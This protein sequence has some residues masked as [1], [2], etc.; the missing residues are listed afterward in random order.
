[1]LTILAPTYTQVQGNWTLLL[2]DYQSKDPYPH[3]GDTCGGL[4][5][6]YVRDPHC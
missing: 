4:P 6:D 2:N 3:M 1:V 5:P